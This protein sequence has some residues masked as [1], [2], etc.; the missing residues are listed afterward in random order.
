MK[1]I[2]LNFTIII[3]F[4]TISLAFVSCK[5]DNHPNYE[6]LLQG[7]WVNTMVNEQPVLTDETFTME[8]KAENTQLY[9]SGFQLDE[10]NKSWLENSNFTYSIS[11]SLIIIDGTDML[12]NSYHIVYNILSINEY[13]LTYSVQTFTMN[14]EEIANTNIYSCKKVTEDFSTEFVGI[15]YGR[16]TTVGNADSL[17]HYWECTDNGDYYYYYQDENGNW[18]K[19]IETGS[20]YF[21]YGQLMAGNYSFDIVGGGTGL[22]FECWDFTLDGNK[23]VWTGLRENNITITYEM[24]KVSSPLETLP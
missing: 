23:M 22:T 11:G 5:K 6:E 7:T 24:E 14:D 18:V 3:V 4:I 21:L 17:F 15:W 20:N 12:G 19:K 9:S 8:F 1:N 16:C 13:T 10:N 2:K